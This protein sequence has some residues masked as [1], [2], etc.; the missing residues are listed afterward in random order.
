MPILKLRQNNV[1]ALPHVGH[2]AKHQC[3]YWDEA[4]PCFGLRVYPSG[5]RMYVC[6]YRVRRRKR[7]ASLGRADVL[8]L[9]QARKKAITYL[10]KVA[11]NEDPQEELEQ[12]R[13]QRTVAE[14]CTAFIEN[15]AKKKRVAWKD[16]E[17]CLKRRILPKLKARPA[18]TI[19]SADIE[20]IHSA[21]C[22]QT[23]PHRAIVTISDERR[24]TSSYGRHLFLRWRSGSGYLML[25]SPSYADGQR[26]QCR[27]A[28]TGLGSNPGSPSGDPLYRHRRRACRNS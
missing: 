15:H 27:D 4:L 13:S 28:V 10:G 18:A 22:S 7:L 21:C 9:D 17:S 11:A 23:I 12:L 5:R 16:D 6:S 8:T 3:I 19:V 14:L 25:R 1:S 2:G 20:A 24:S 26:Y